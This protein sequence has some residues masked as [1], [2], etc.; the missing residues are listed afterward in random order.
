MKERFNFDPLALS[1]FGIIEVLQKLQKGEKS[2]F[3]YQ[4]FNRLN[5]F[6]FFKNTSR[7]PKWLK[8]CQR[9]KLDVLFYKYIINNY[10]LKN[11]EVEDLFCSLSR[12]IDMKI[13]KYATFFDF[14]WSILW[15]AYGRV[16]LFFDSRNMTIHFYN[17]SMKNLCQ[18]VTN[19]KKKEFLY[20]T[21]QIKNRWK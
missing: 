16:I 15:S 10:L 21:S 14:N 4:F 3:H 1:R 8:I 5:L 11:T 6:E 20:F 19:E 7:I 9:V 13:F 12:L 2:S 18:R 17:S